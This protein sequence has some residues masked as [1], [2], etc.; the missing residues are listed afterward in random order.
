VGEYWTKHTHPNIL[1]YF[2]HNRIPSLPLGLPLGLNLRYFFPTFRIV[3]VQFEET[4]FDLGTAD[5]IEI[6]RFK[7]AEKSGI[8]ELG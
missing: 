4:R 7:Q 8:L 6:Q 3:F 2:H 5:L 1:A